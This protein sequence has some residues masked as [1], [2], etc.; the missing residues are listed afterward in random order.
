MAA[1]GSQF[2]EEIT[3]KIMEMFDGAFLNGKELRIP[4][5]EDGREIQIKVALTCA[6]EN[7]DRPAGDTEPK[8]TIEQ[9]SPPN[10]EKLQVTEQEK[11]NIQNLIEA[12]N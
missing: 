7:V 1:K 4:G 12:L 10:V 5:L 2:K 9:A 11:Q 8:V 3:Q 6:K